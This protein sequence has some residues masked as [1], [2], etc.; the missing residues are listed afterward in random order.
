[1]NSRT[2]ESWIKQRSSQEICPK[3]LS[4][5]ELTITTGPGTAEVPNGRMAGVPVSLQPCLPSCHLPAPS[6]SPLSLA[7]LPPQRLR[8]R[9]RHRGTRVLWDRGSGTFPL[10]WDPTFPGR[11]GG[12]LTASQCP[13]QPGTA[14]G[15]RPPSLVPACPPPSPT[16]GA[17]EHRGPSPAPAGQSPRGWL[18]YR[19]N[20]LFYTT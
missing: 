12:D 14:R 9:H 17:V 7:L 16:V 2:V 1:M 5:Q 3:S 13:G 4:Q 15:N 10:L 8:D 18:E 19:V 6:L 20:I 11:T